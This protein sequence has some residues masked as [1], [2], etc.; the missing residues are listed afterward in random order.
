[1]FNNI[2]LFLKVLKVLKLY[3]ICLI[4]N[5]M[6]FILIILQ[7]DSIKSQDN[8]FNLKIKFNNKI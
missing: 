5:Y 4:F 3:F 6:N 7:F 8:F 1:M 2:I